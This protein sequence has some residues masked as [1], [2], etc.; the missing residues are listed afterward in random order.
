MTEKTDEIAIRKSRPK[1]I[2]IIMPVY[3]S[4]RQF[5]RS[6][7]NMTQW[8]NGYPSRGAILADI[9]AGNH[10]IGIDSKGMPA[11]VFAL[12]LGPDPTYDIIE[13]GAW[14]HNGPYGTIHRLASTGRHRGIL[15]AC[16]AFALKL[17][18]TIRLDTHADNSAMLSAARRLGYVRC[19]VI[20][21]QDGTP[22][23]AMQLN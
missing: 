19:G 17:A 9:A 7:G 18:D 14:P 13:D 16:T 12:I 15:A 6:K 2:D 22:R 4:A 3:D 1:D 11:M 21:C 8:T 23:I 10:Y 20:Y 5:M